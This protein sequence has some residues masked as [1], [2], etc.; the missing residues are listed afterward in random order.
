MKGHL[1]ERS[2]GH[3][4]IVIDVPDPV[5]GKRRRKWHSFKG[6]KRQAQIESAR[7]ISALSSDQYQEPSKATVGDFLDGWHAYMRMQVSPRTHERYGELVR[8]HLKPLLG[9]VA[10]TKLRGDRVAAAYAATLDAGLSPRTVIYLH[11]ILKHALKDAVRWK[12]IN[13]NPCADVDP[14]RAEK[15]PVNTYDMAQTADLLSLVSESRVAIAVML[16]V[17]CGLRRGEI[18]ALRWKNVDFDGAQIAIVES[19]EQTAAGVRYKETKTG[20]DRTVAL[21]ATMIDALREHR[22]RQPQTEFVYT[23]EDGKPMQPRSLTRA[24]EAKIAGTALPRLRFHDLR[25]SHATHMLG[26]GVH[27]KIASERLGHSKISTTA[28]LYMHATKSMQADAVAVVD[29]ALRFAVNKRAKT[30]R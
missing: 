13:S 22:E 10:L 11:R 21:S 23:R 19:A 2:P 30:V 24:W 26:S 29:A 5:S 28:D 1:K 25:H 7:L 9:A 8:V 14:P 18:C 16:A 27:L 12:R 20:H 3:W 4:A 17:L 15:S 6:T